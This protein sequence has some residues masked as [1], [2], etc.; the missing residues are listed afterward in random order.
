[1]SFHSLHAYNVTKKS[2]YQHFCFSLDPVSMAS[3]VAVVLLLLIII[4]L[5]VISLLIAYKKQKACFKGN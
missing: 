2:E 1:M 4:L 3:V 5:L